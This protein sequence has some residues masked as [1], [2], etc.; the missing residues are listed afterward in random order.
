MANHKK[1]EG[2]NVTDSKPSTFNPIQKGGRFMYYFNAILKETGDEIL[3]EMVGGK[4]VQ[5]EFRNKFGEEKFDQLVE[6]FRKDSEYIAIN[7]MKWAVTPKTITGLLGYYLDTRGAEYEKA[8]NGYYV[9]EED[10]YSMCE[11]F[12]RVDEN[13]RKITLTHDLE[14]PVPEKKRRIVSRLLSK[15]NNRIYITEP[16]VG[17]HKGHVR[18]KVSRTIRNDIKS[19][20]MPGD[21]MRVS[22]VFD[23]ID[24]IMESYQEAHPALMA[25]FYEDA[26]TN[27]ALEL[28][29]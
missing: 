27:E 24:L 16:K 25:V 21:V 17:I 14:D 15:I 2:G 5:E 10:G 18:W 28:I 4:S 12:F 7:R 6:I 9:W 8:D 11:M 20:S 22:T 23:M 1:H 3:K 26:N 29:S 19:D 13:K